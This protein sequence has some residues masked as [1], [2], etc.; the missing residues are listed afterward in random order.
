MAIAKAQNLSSNDGT[1]RDGSMKTAAEAIKVAKSRVSEAS[2]V[3]K[4]ARDLADSVISGT[5]ATLP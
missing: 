4:Y 3:L 1:K 5:T 2:L